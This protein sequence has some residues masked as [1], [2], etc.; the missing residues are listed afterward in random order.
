MQ[1]QTFLYRA[2]ILYCHILYRETIFMKQF[3][4]IEAM[5]L[6]TLQEPV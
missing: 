2:I 1:A 6:P 4:Y 3:L 5:P